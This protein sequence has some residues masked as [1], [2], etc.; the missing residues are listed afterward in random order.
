MSKVA[1][2]SWR[3]WQFS[4]ANSGPTIALIARKN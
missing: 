1:L 2:I 4:C 3:W